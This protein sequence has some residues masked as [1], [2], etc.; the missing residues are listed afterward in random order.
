VELAQ[1]L[2]TS[3]QG[4]SATAATHPGIRLTT[5]QGLLQ[6]TNRAGKFKIDLSKEQINFCHVYR[7]ARKNSQEKKF[8]KFFQRLLTK[9]A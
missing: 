2:S 6:I 4:M 7:P 5:V 9:Q 1:R 8:V 3:S